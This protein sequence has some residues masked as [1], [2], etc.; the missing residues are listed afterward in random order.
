MNRALS[1]ARQVGL[2]A[3][4]LLLAAC[5]GEAEESDAGPP[6]VQVT[7][8]SAAAE[9]VRTVERTLGTITAKAEP[10]VAA[11]V[12]ARVQHIHADSG[13]H[14][15]AGELLAELDTEDFERHIEQA[16]AEINRLQALIRNQERTVERNRDLVEENFISETALDDSEAELEALREELVAARSRLRSSQRDLERTRIEAPTT[17]DIEARHVSEGDFVQTGTVLFHM[18]ATERLRIRL[19]FPEAVAGRVRVGQEVNLATPLLGGQQVTGE[20]TEIQ[21]LVGRQTQSLIA[22]AEVDNPGGWRPGATVDAELL[23]EERDS[24]TVPDQSV[25][26]RPAGEVVYVIDDDGDEVIARNVE[27]GERTR[28]RA[29]I[30]SGL[31]PGER[32]VVDGAGF[33]TDG[34]RVDASPREG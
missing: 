23:V 11:E 16:Q 34:A 32:V 27:L 6:A 9:P 4:L 10:R 17:G 3:L 26:R 8:I 12:A 14:V 18:T 33:L 31:D 28:D 29:E 22:I 13:Q 25:V 24:V 7:Y 30:L 19:P 5:G 2:A 20:I 1:T 15:S 21:P